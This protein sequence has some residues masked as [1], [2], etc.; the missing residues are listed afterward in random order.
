MK[1]YSN[2]TWKGNIVYNQHQFL[3]TSEKEFILY[4]KQALEG[5]K[6]NVSYGLLIFGDEGDCVKFS[7]FENHSIMFK[8]VRPDFTN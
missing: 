2:I 8:L 3:A 7:N 1:Y 5:S 4:L 6:L